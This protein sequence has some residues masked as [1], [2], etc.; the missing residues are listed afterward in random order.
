MWMVI[1]G[2]HLTMQTTLTAL[3]LDTFQKKFIGNKNNIANI[4]G[5]QAYNLIIWGYFVLDLLIYL[6][7]RLL[8]YTTLFSHNEYEKNDKT[9]LKYFQ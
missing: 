3:K 2:V 6:G 5:I 1:T 8:D 4:Y 9:M 7:K